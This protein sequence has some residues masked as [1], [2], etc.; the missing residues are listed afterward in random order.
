LILDG[1][2]ENEIIIIDSTNKTNIVVLNSEFGVLTEN[3]RFITENPITTTPTA[4]HSDN[5]DE[6]YLIFFR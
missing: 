5:L 2:G 4:F 3:A 6:T 1:D